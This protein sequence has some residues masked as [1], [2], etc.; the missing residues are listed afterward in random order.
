MT[1]TL[2]VSLNDNSDN[3]FLISFLLQKH[4]IIRKQKIKN[5]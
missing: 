2:V 3:N 5:I 4:K 1:A